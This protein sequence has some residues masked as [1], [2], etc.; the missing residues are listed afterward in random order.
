MSIF[1]KAAASKPASEKMVKTHTL[2]IIAVCFVFGMINLATGFTG[3]GTIIILAGLVT[4]GVCSFILKKASTTTRGIILSQ[5]QLAIIIVMSAAKHEMHGMFP[6]MAAAM[7][8]AAVYFNKQNLFINWAMIDA[9]AVIGIIFR[10][11]FYG[12]AGLELV[13]KGLLGLNIS[14]ALLVYVVDCCLG[15]IKESQDAENEANNLLD[16]VKEQSDGSALLVEQ[17]KQ[18]VDKISDIS[19]RVSESANLMNDIAGRISSAAE[20]QDRT[21]SQIVD[22]ITNI[23][24]EIQNSYNESENVAKAAQESTK[25]INDG[26]EEIQRMLTAMA[27][28]NEASGKIESIIRTIEDIAFQTN[29]LALNAA[30]EAARA[31][32]AGK[33][34]A[35]VADE[36]RNLATESADA[37][38]NTS[39]LIQ[40]S[41]S[42]VANGTRITKRMANH[43]SEIME[44]AEKSAKHASV[45]TELTGSQVEAIVAVKAK[46]EQ[47]SQVVAM[48]VQTS[49]ESADIARSVLEEVILMEDIVKSD[50]DDEQEQP[51]FGGI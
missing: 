1:S 24:D 42:A 46:I 41:L 14:A 34:F 12:E 16:R 50:E 40:S 17:Q 23:S 45:I 5:V 20:E 51:A 18:V 6:L 48:N 8:I 4:A 31:G 21:V 22:D 32:E 11:F 37:A 36:V 43:M 3:L 15:Y 26:N 7:A 2:V 35:V 30:V 10:S 47:I 29:I 44:G 39:E 28:I 49:V 27:D 19:K 38:K 9:S 33:G 25:M 13:I